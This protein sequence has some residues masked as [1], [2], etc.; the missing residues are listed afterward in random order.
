VTA[1]GKRKRRIRPP[2]VA[3]IVANSL[4][5][6][7]LSGTLADGDLLPKQEELMTE[8]GVS[9]PAIR[10]AFRI[11]ETEGLVTVLRGNVGGAIV[12]LPQAETAAYMM[13]LVLQSRGAALTDLVEGMRRLEPVCAAQAAMRPD[14]ATTVLPRLRDNLDASMAAIDDPDTFIS[15][16]R[17]FHTVLVA[18]CGNETMAL[19]V[20]SLER[21]W[22]AQVDLLARHKEVH[23]SF[24]DRALRLSLAREHE[25]IY[26]AIEDGDALG[27]ERA[28]VEHF[29]GGDG[30][31]RH[32]F[33][34][35][36]TVIASALRI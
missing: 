25:R 15:L 2:R 26:R 6:R 18:H 11:L 20:G 29:S 30:E 1:D 10:E 35:S 12:H 4:R 27:A 28:I 34:T 31:R 16:A 7:I 33:D 8:Y 17:D 32:G 13:G 14:R 21:L 19:V 24:G 23:G 5:D 9:P 3:E 22:T 36:T